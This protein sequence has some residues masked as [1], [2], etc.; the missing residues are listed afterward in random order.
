MSFPMANRN[1]PSSAVM[2]SHDELMR[3][4]APM[5]DAE[6]LRDFDDCLLP[7]ADS[8]GSAEALKEYAWARRKARDFSP[9]KAGA[10]NHRTVMDSDYLDSGRVCEAPD[11]ERPIRAKRANARF[12]SPRC[13]KRGQRASAA[14]HTASR[15]AA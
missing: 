11:C 13:Q 10:C 5:T 1:W 7:L 14:H 6:L 15:A 9:G 8:T 2:P 3:H 4:A 12:C